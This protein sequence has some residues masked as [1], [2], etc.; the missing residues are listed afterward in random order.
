MSNMTVESEMKT[1]FMNDGNSIRGLFVGLTTLDYVYYLEN[2]PS[3]NQKVKT[4]RYERYVG[5]PAANAA[6][7]Y[8]LLGGDATLVTCLGDSPEAKLISDILSSYGVRVIN[9]ASD[10]TMP[11]IATITVDGK[12]NRT[13]FSGQKHFGQIQIP[14]YGKP[15]FVLFDLNQQD[16]SLEILRTVD[17]QIIL[18]A[19][20]WK[21]HAEEFLDRADIIIASE[22]FKNGNGENILEMRDLS[23][24]R[25]AITRGNRDILTDNISISVDT[26]IECVDSLAAGDIFHGAFCYAYFHQKESFE[27]ALHFANKTAQ[28]SVRYFGPREWAKHDR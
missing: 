19:G 20:N 16:I 2:Y 23:P 24:K 5:G 26:T 17:A 8:A 22:H 28:E 9:C 6:I 12:G 13:I 21:D 3:N 7:T 18:D 14:P 10:Q 4:D 27:D 1:N 25:R 15:D 11:N